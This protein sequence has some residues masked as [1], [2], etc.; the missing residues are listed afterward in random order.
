M[1]IPSSEKLLTVLLSSWG[2][3]LSTFLAGIK[4]A[5][6]LQ[7]QTRIHVSLKRDMKIY[8]VSAE[9]GEKTYIIVT[10]ANRSQRPMFLGNAG[11]VY[12]KTWKQGHG[13]CIA[14]NSLRQPQ[15]TKLEEGMVYDFM[16]DQ[17][18]VERNGVGPGSYVGFV[19]DRTGRT[20]YSHGWF[21]RLIRIW[22]FK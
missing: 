12:R 15:P 14:T 7:G 20:F 18:S 5:E 8:P 21:G 10:G 4:L 3:L 11:L 13:G 17:E 2:A 9:Y 16:I 19:C 22:R 1:A 6:F